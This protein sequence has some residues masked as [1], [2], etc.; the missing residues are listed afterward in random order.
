MLAARTSKRSGLIANASILAEV[1]MEML[2]TYCATKVF[3][4]YL[5][6]SVAFEQRLESKNCKNIDILCLQPHLVKT[7]MIQKVIDAGQDMAVVPVEAC[8]GAAMRDLSHEVRTYGPVLHE[9]FAG[10]FGPI[11]KYTKLIR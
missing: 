5:C 11:L 7:K 4:K 10:I 2:F 6:Q 3:V 8:V 1:P 9:S